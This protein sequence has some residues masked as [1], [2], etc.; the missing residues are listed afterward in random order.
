MGLSALIG[1]SLASSI[2]C[3]RSGQ[4][5]GNTMVYDEEDGVTI[6]LSA[7]LSTKPAGLLVGPPE[8]M[9][10]GVDKDAT[11]SPAPQEAADV[12]PE[13]LQKAGPWHPTSV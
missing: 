12:E 10:N 13:A 6:Q 1:C 7:L 11:L 2:V 5:G 9:A 4:I 8:A 3:L